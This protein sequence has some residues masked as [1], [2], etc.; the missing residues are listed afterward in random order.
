MKN[1]KNQMKKESLGFPIGSL[2]CSCVSVLLLLAP[3][4]GLPLAITGIV[5]GCQR[6]HG[7]STAGKVIGIVSVVLN[8]MF[9][10][11]VILVLMLFPS[12]IYL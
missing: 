2:V 7:L 5:L 9:L 8:S 1:E 4:F 6:K 10:L 12:L 3:Y 11:L